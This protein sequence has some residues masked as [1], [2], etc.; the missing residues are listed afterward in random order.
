MYYYK[1]FRDLSS[2]VRKLALKDWHVFYAE[3]KLE[4][5][6]FQ[7]PYIIPKFCITIDYELVFTVSVFNWEIPVNHYIYKDL[8]RTVRLVTVSVLIRNLDSAIICDG[9][10]V[11]SNCGGSIRHCIPEESKEQTLNSLPFQARDFYLANECQVLLRSE[12]KCTNCTDK[13]TVYAKN[14]KRLANRQAIP[15]K[16]KAPVSLTSSK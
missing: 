14:K 4:M 10:N 16:P 3:D 6:K 15:A 7:T 9:H 12:L 13:E 8:K 5:K 1:D 11:E 2:R